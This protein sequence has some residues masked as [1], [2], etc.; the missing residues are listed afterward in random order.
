[1]LLISVQPQELPEH[2]CLGWQKHYPALPGIHIWRDSCG[3]PPGNKQREVPHRCKTPLMTGSPYRRNRVCLMGQLWQRNQGTPHFGYNNNKSRLGSV[4]KPVLQYFCNMSPSWRASR[5][6]TAAVEVFF[7]LLLFIPLLTI[8]MQP[9]GR[10][11][12]SSG[13]AVYS[14]LT[15]KEKQTQ[16]H[17]I[18]KTKTNKQKPSDQP[19]TD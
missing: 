17:K 14:F 12:F 18:Q 4:M 5:H 9:L 6:T 8:C 15:H 3:S 2:R 19:K 11:C 1:M 13:W 10:W 16:A 7:C